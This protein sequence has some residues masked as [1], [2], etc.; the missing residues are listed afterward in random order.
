MN[1]EANTT[2][3]S[4]NSEG[5]KRFGDDSYPRKHDKGGRLRICRDF[6]KIRYNS[7]VLPTGMFV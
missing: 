3:K 7:C 4:R 6:V 5:R 2:R 1:S